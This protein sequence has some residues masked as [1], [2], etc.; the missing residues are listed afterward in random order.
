M[1]DIIHHVIA[2]TLQRPV[3]S[4][5]GK[6]LA[7]IAADDRIYLINLLEAVNGHQYITAPELPK[8]TRAFLKECNIL[9]WSPETLV[10]LD[11]AEDVR[12][13]SSSQCESEST[14]I[15][16]SN[17]SRLVV[18]STNL[19]SPSTSSDRGTTVGDPAS[20]KSD[21]LADYDLGSQYGKLSFAEFVLNHRHVL[22]MFEF[23]TTAAILNLTKPQREEIPHVKF[24]DSRSFAAAP[25]TRY[26]ALLRRDKSQDKVTVFELKDDNSITYKSFDTNTLDA[27]SL[28]WCPAG[29]PILAICESPTYGAKVCFYTIQGHALTQLDISRAALPRNTEVIGGTPPVDMEGVGATFWKWTKADDKSLRTIQVAAD[30]EGRVVV[31]MLTT[32]MAF[33]I[34]GAFAHPEL[35]DGSRTAV[36]QES[37]HSRGA[38]PEPMAKFTRHAGTFEALQ[39]QPQPK[40]T[41]TRE[42][43]AQK[44][45]ETQNQVELVTI[46]SD[47]T[48][49]AT[50]LRSSPRTLYLWRLGRGRSHHPHTVLVF[51]HAVRQALWH[52]WLS[53]VL[54]IVT[55]R[56][57]PHIYAWYSKECA[58]ISGQIPLD[59]NTRPSTHLSATWLPQCARKAD[60]DSGASSTGSERCP[61]LVSSSAAFQVG[62]VSVKEGQLAFES[63]FLLDAVTR[64]DSLETYPFPES[65]DNSD[66]VIDTPS[67]PS[68]VPNNA[69]RFGDPEQ[70]PIMEQHSSVEAQTTYLRW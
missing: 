55:M 4:P 17:G 29:R 66:M 30:G 70:P 45:K 48:M 23:G 22:I 24:N 11:E 3:L 54:L 63:I 60:D 38:L 7:V 36:W 32:G 35:I 62:H 42:E 58:P 44:E 1:G 52:P 61:F 16:L 12:L 33:E 9:R 6:F 20:R 8:S 26:F 43:Q 59:M 31:R 37:P 64:R 15:L 34:L 50:K 27:Q 57:T 18:L 21:I 46:N 49:A 41:Q 28:T 19:P 53:S 68:R 69:A 40:T 56:K 51:N 65:E 5:D 25:D 13:K 67:R 14:W 2:N 39:P 10:V 47:Q